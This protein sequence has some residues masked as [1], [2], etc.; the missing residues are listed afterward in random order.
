MRLWICTEVGGDG[1]RR[2]ANSGSWQCR[3]DGVSNVESL[4]GTFRLLHI[5]PSPGVGWPC[6][7]VCS[8]LRGHS[9][10]SALV[11]VPELICSFVR[12]STQNFLGATFCQ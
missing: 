2:F 4:L 1:S 11:S 8:M 3:P 6:P 10:P 5:S 7:L 12:A 9:M